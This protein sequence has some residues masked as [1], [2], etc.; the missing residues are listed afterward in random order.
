MDRETFLR[1]CLEEDPEAIPMEYTFETPD[2]VLAPHRVRKLVL[3]IRQK[4]QDAF[5]AALIARDPSKTMEE[6]VRETTKSIRD[7]LC[8]KPKYAKFA[9][10]N[11]HKRIFEMITSPKMKAPDFAKI[12]ALIDLREQI[13]NGTID[14]KTG[15]D[16]LLSVIGRP[17]TD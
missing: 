5:T 16:H 15:M 2:R 4:F 3:E 17:K 12:L 1:K 8:K 7:D 6:F 10:E 13:D 14:E 9:R 11:D